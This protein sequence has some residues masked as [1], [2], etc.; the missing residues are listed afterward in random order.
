L[1][2]AIEYQ[3]FIKQIQKE[4]YDK[5]KKKRIIKI[6]E[7]LLNDKKEIFYRDEHNIKYIQTSMKGKII[8]TLKKMKE[9][10]KKYWFPKFEITQLD[11]YVKKVI[12]QGKEIEYDLSEKKKER[13]LKKNQEEYKKPILTKEEKEELK[14]K[15]IETIKKKKEKEELKRKKAKNDLKE[16]LKN[17]KNIFCFDIENYEKDR[18]KV[19]EIGY[20]YYIVEE[21]VYINKNILIEENIEL[22]NGEFVSNNKYNFDFG[23]TEIKPY[24]E[25][26]E[27]I[28]KLMENSEIIVGH[29]IQNDFKIIPNIKNKKVFD[30]Q[31]VVKPEELGY[32]GQL[33]LY[34]IASAY[35]LYPENLHN[36]GN[37]AYFTLQ[38]ALRMCHH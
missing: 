34:K 11:F 32:K 36:A 17:K 3:N 7:E 10:P 38:T 13:D 14:R 20:S 22:E 25:A 30:T 12:E 24:K 8:N 33:S 23:E 31:K 37:D 1:I 16:V 21:D 15:K 9:N 35:L 26:I 4:I 5:E 18:K 29:D 2:E 27:E 28:N 6:V 19:L